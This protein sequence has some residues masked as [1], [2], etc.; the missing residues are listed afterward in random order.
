MKPQPLLLIGAGGHAAA[1]IDVVELDGRCS[2][3]GLVA[4]APELGKQ[5]FGYPVVGTD[6]DLPELIEKYPN[7]LIGIGHI[8]TPE[9]RIRI[10]DLLQSLG[11]AMPVVVS[12]RAYVSR[13]A[14]V[15]AGSI[16][17]HGAVVNAGAVIGR[18]CI[19]NSQSLVEHYVVIADHCHVSTAAAINGGV[20]VG[21]GTFIGSGSSVR[22][23]IS[24]GE[25]CRIGMGQ[26]VTADCAAGTLQLGDSSK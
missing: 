25:G 24:I 3:V 11:C 2:V 18:N 13:H 6:E 14:S 4:S 23:G 15:G 5:L 21:T 9:P 12:S 26:K 1:C 16:I 19:I 20:R 17:M 8:K 7:A 22:E 10:F